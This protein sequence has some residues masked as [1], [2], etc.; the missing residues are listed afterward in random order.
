MI[1]QVGS[2]EGEAGIDSDGVGP[3][4]RDVDAVEMGRVRIQDGDCGTKGSSDFSVLE[5]TAL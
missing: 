3:D 5:E 2:T 1:F 4:I